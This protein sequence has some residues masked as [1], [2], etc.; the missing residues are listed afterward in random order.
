MGLLQIAGL[1]PT[2]WGP[3]V[4]DHFHGRICSTLGNPNFLAAWVVGILPFLVWGWKAPGLMLAALAAAVLLLTGSK[5]GLLGLLAAAAVTLVALR[6]AGLLPPA[7]TPRAR[8]LR[9]AV[10]A[11]GLALLLAA[12]PAGTRSRLFAPGDLARNESVRF[13]LLTWTQTAKMARATPLLGRGIGRYQVVYPR[14]RLPE[15]IRMFGQHSYMTDHPENLTLEILAELG[16]AGLLLW[17]WLLGA[18]ARRAWRRLAGPDPDERWL[19]VA[20]LG[21]L[22]GLFV[23]NSFGVDIHYGSTAALGACVLGALLGSR[24]ETPRP[25]PFAIRWGSVFAAAILCLLWVRFY[26]SDA[27]LARAMAAS[28]AGRWDVAVPA[29]ARAIEL[30]PANV[31]ARYFGASALLDRGRDE[32]LPEAKR[33]LESVRSEAP[34]Y[35][36]VSYKEWLLYNRLG[37]RREAEA[38]LARQISLDPLAS[39]FYLD[40]GRLAMEER[41]WHDAERDFETAIR[42]EPDNPSGF[43]FLGNFLVVRGRL[44]EALAVYDRG[45][46]VHPDSE[47]LHYNAAVAAYKL[48]DRRLART[49][50]EAVLRR[51]P[52]HA[53]ARVIWTKTQ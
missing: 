52:G 12:M 7:A 2:P 8:A 42:V 24:R 44:R 21:S 19:G 17:L 38:A 26:A 41:R 35:V 53:A 3:L 30:S 34:D 1:D 25:E 51:N 29:Y 36:L 28:T 5:G 33:L 15:I 4:R 48:G 43:Q 16:L 27:A 9:W 23:T 14:Y 11:A 50:A 10:P 46:A 31:M 47:E 40:R 6:R 37:L 18:A 22:A 45:L 49:H 20:G 13:R 39:V 32:D